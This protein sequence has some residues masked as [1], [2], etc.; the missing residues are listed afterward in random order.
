MTDIEIVREAIELFTVHYFDTIEMAGTVKCHKKDNVNYIGI[1]LRNTKWDEDLEKLHQSLLSYLKE[2]T[3]RNSSNF[4]DH[5]SISRLTIQYLLPKKDGANQNQSKHVK[6]FYLPPYYYRSSQESTGKPYPRFI[7]KILVI[8]NNLLLRNT[9]LTLLLTVILII[10]GIYKIKSDKEFIE[11]LIKSYDYIN[12]A[13]GIMA[14]LVLGFLVTKVIAIR[15]DKQKHTGVVR[16]LSNKLTYFRN[17]CYRLAG[18]HN[19]WSTQHPAYKSYQY[20]NSIKHDITFEE[21]YYP[22]YDDDVEYA[23]F[24][25]FYNP[26]LSH[27]VISLILQLHMMAGDSFLDS[28]L[29]YTKFPPNHI[30]SHD[31]MEKFALFS[32]SNLIWYC[33]SEAKIFPANFNNSYAVKEIIDDVNRIYPDNKIS[34]L[35]SEK[36]ENVSLDFQYQIIPRLYNLTRVVDAGLPITI[37][38]FVVTFILLLVFGVIIPTLTYVFIDKAYAFLSVFPSIGIIT[39][40]LLT[41]K[42]ILDTENTLDKKYDYL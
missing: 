24:K 27:S 5:V 34:T 35:T 41:L 38:Y 17:I 15:Q 13:S 1:D 37:N 8:W 18:D 39:H 4:K 16:E 10:I 2:W 21:Y 33:S 7:L 14:S 20:A 22:N 36:L 28:G 11:R 42:P 26:D 9:I 30:Y 31:E 3:Q 32:D 6:L 40:I 19:Y 23:K 25:S 12:I 29:T